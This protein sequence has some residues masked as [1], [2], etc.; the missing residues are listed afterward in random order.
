MDGKIE[1][2]VWFDAIR[3]PDAEARVR[4]IMAMSKA[5]KDSFGD[6]ITDIGYQTEEH[7]KLLLSAI[8]EQFLRAEVARL[9]THLPP[10]CING[11]CP[12]ED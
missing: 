8:N 10:R 7:R 4:F 1:L 2:D 12:H 9:K 6:L 3:I 5:L 11:S